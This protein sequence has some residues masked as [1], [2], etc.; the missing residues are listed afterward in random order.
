MTSNGNIKPVYVVLII[1]G[2]AVMC[3]VI[4][5]VNYKVL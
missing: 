1:L 2:A 5:L 3:G 4:A